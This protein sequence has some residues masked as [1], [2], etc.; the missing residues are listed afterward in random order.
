MRCSKPDMG[1]CRRWGVVG[2][3]ERMVSDFGGVDWAV[4][5]EVIMVRCGRAGRDYL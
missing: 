2:D 5:F 4:F 3:E 1:F